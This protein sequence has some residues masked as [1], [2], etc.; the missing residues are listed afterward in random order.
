VTVAENPIKYDIDRIKMIP[1]DQQKIAKQAIKKTYKDHAPDN[2]SPHGDLGQLAEKEMHALFP[3]SIKGGASYVS[4]KHLPVGNKVR[5]ECDY[6]LMKPRV[7]KA[8]SIYPKHDKGDY[9]GMKAGGRPAPQ[10]RGL[11]AK[12]K[13]IAVVSDN[14]SISK[15]PFVNK[16]VKNV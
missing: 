1:E 13:A 9:S 12:T 16:R 2:I 3:H 7:D 11:P 5:V 4:S 6:N 8:E 15:W 10:R 14:G